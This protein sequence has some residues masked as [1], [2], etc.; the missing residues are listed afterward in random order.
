MV[1][2][3]PELNDASV[4]AVHHEEYGGGAIAEPSPRINTI[5]ETKTYSSQL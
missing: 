4:S 2:L 5:N 3:S 1:W